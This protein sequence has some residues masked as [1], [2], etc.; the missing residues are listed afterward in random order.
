MSVQLTK[1]I[2]MVTRLLP[3]ENWQEV[4]E[5]IANPNWADPAGWEDNDK[6]EQ[7]IPIELRECWDDLP[8][9]LKIG[10]KLVADEGPSFPHRSDSDW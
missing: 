10:A 2:A 6:W 1:T 9:E 8:L 4:I 5:A 3:D 7:F